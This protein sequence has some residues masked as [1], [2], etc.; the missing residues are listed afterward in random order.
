[1]AEETM[2]GNS[3][4]S[5]FLSR[6]DLFIHQEYGS[7]TKFSKAIGIPASTLSSYFA[8][9]KA[10]PTL[11]F[12]ESLGNTHPELDLGWLITGRPSSI[13]GHIPNGH[14]MVREGQSE[15]NGLSGA[16][17]DLTDAI[18]NANFGELTEAIRDFTK[19]EK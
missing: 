19:T 17:L 16:I 12:F 2:Y 14:G 18:Q 7:R 13:N 15:Y 6:L 4:E 1:M 9:K 10:K 5:T 3:N 8:K 11:D